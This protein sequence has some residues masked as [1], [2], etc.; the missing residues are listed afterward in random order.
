MSAIGG[1]ADIAWRPALAYLF[2]DFFCFLA[3]L[4]PL[5]QA[6][7]ALGINAATTHKLCLV[8]LNLLSS[9]RG[10]SKSS[11]VLNL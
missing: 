3:F 5:K 2:A 1:R 8:A 9:R 6:V 4:F 10:G 7:G 11:I